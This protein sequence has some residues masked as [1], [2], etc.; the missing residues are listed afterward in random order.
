MSD[1]DLNSDAPR[2]GDVLRAKRE[3]RDL[4]LADVSAVLL[5]KKEYLKAIEDM[6]IGGLPK[7]G[8][9]SGI[10]RS[11]ANY[12]GVNAEETISAFNTQCGALSQAPKRSETIALNARTRSILQASAAG[13][14]AALTLMVVGG[15]GYTLF[16][17]SSQE[18]VQ[19]SDTV[20]PATENDLRTS[21]FASTKIDEAAPQLPLTLTALRNAWLEVR[22]ADGTIF[23]SRRMAAGEVYHPRIGAGWTVSARNGGAF[24]WHV[25]DIEIGPLGDVDAPVYSLNVDMVAAKAQEAT[26]PSLAAVTEAQPSR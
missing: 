1:V 6:Y 11:Y 18:P 8:Y 9:V 20:V 15:I 5:V 2:I 13:I 10:L 16:T 24:V 3:A 4:S 12:L 21:L 25:G 22:G 26:A 7:G 23:R 14:A 17:S 19:V